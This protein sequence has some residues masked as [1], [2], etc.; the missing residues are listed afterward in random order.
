M[1][2]KKKKLV[3]SKDH[4]FTFR[5]YGPESKTEFAKNR[6]TVLGCES[7][8]KVLLIHEKNQSLKISCYCPFK[9][10]Q[11]ELGKKWKNN[12]QKYKK[13]IFFYIFVI[14][15]MTK[16][17]SWQYMSNCENFREHFRIEKTSFKQKPLQNKT[18]YQK[19]KCFE[20]IL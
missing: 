7:G 6:E 5:V 1:I 19:G 9:A 20:K 11:I 14:E 13:I 17:D 4:I 2:F 12:S 8:A 18:T 15:N 3:S 10:A 16:I